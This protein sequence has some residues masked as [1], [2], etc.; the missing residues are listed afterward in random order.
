MLSYP[1]V[2]QK[3]AHSQTLCSGKPLEWA[4]RAASESRIPPAAA[5]NSVSV[6]SSGLF[7]ERNPLKESIRVY[8]L[9]KGEDKH[10]SHSKYKMGKGSFAFTK[11]NAQLPT[12]PTK[13][14]QFAL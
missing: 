9:L 2:T 14:V 1:D 11:P 10:S 12:E 13:K 8:K 5:Q 6:L 4:Q 3:P 7:V